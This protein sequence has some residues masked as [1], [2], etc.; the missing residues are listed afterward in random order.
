MYHFFTFCFV[1]VAWICL[2]GKLDPFHLGLGVLSSLLVA[3]ITTNLLFV[4]R[5]PWSKRLVRPLRCLVYFFWLL[6]QIVV[7]NWHVL[8]LTLSRRV[9]AREMDPH[10]VH[11]PTRL[12]S[13]FARFVLA[14]SITLT[15]GTV[16]I[17][18]HGDSF[19]IHAISRAAAASLSTDSAV[20]DME[21]WVGWAFEG[22]SL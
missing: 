12:Q 10:V 13:D 22:W 16:T 14:N 4:S 19:T 9:M 17:R 1:L 5:R 18:I 2:S 20:G 6:Y 8:R 21:R 15:P 7:A 11:F 3:R